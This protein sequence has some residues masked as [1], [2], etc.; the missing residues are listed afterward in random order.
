MVD[1]IATATQ[2]AL[3]IKEQAAMSIG[4]AAARPWTFHLRDEVRLELRIK[5]RY[6]SQRHW[7]PRRSFADREGVTEE[8]PIG[9]V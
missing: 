8:N 7:I 1:E 5:S 2:I 9:A 6:A 4:P 3:A